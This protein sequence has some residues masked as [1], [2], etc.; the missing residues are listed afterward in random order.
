MG[1]QQILFLALILVT[2]LVSGMALAQDGGPQSPA[3]STEA[4]NAA[5]LATVGTSFTYQGRLTDGGSPADGEYD[6]RFRLYDA[7]S[8]GAQVGG[9]VAE[10]D[11]IVTDGLFTVQ[12]DFGGGGFT[13]QARYLEIG[14]R[15]GSSTGGYTDLA[16]RQPLTPA[17]YALALPGLWTQQN[18][19]SPNLIGGYSGNS[20]GIGV[21][22]ATISGGGSSSLLNQVTGD[23]ATIGG[24]WGNIASGPYVAI[25]GGWSNTADSDAATVCG[26]HNNVAG[27]IEATVGGGYGNEA[28]HEYT[29]IGGGWNNVASFGAA[30]I[31][32]GNDNQATNWDATV[33]GGV[34]NTASGYRATVG[35]GRL[36]TAG[37]FYATVGGGYFNAATAPTTTIGGGEYI[38]VTGEAA[39]VAGGS[40]ITT[41]GDYAA[42]GGGQGNAANG[43]ATTVGGG[44]GNTAGV[45]RATVGGGHNNEAG[46]DSATVSGGE[47]NIASGDFVTI[48]GGESNTASEH[49]AT[50]GG[51]GGNAASDQYATVPG[52]HDNTA[53]GRCSFAAGQRARANHDGAFVWGDSTDADVTSPIADSFIVRASGGITMY[54]SGNLLSGAM[55]P[56]GSG[57]WL[58]VSDRDA[59]ENLVPVDGEEVL[60]RLADVPIT[61]WNYKTQAR[62]I[63]HMGPMAQDLH[64]TFG[65]GESERHISTIDADGLALV[66]IQALYQRSQNQA[67]RIEQL[68][69][70]VSSYKEENADLEARVAAL[71][72]VLSNGATPAQVW[73]TNLLPW[74]GALLVGGIVAWA[75]RRRD[76]LGSFGGGGR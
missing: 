29:T 42:V 26:G 54:T 3:D 27:N 68:E 14:V 38:S 17:P 22:G 45:S 37:G 15:P 71:E 34:H 49:G 63:R 9:T 61:T 67:A 30:T 53:Q 23:Y 47:D 76:V 55:L 75:F 10:E 40:W 35:G 11:V 24:G 2:L 50:I 66:S 70:E 18:G 20:V 58:S 31:G 64:A 51:G 41:T 13:G 5:A 73:Q 74:T 21:V 36:N 8:D 52:G 48:G 32:G 44:V 12:L 39:T 28:S 62:S 69:A 56:A 6:F 1:R 16:P 4:P 19:T 57:S 72:V 46:G 43:Y 33:G 7:A 25:A 59:K 60:T 65:L